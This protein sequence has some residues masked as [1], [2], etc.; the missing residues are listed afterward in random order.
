M[1]EQYDDV[2]RPRHYVTADGLECIDVM[3][4]VFGDEKVAIWCQLNAFK[5]VWRAEQK[6]GIQDIQKANWY[7]AKYVELMEKMDK[8]SK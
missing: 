2:T 3:R 4:A 8:E 6:N 1:N 7:T 5:Y